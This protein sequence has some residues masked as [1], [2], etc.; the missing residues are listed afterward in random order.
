MLDEWPMSGAETA[1]PPQSEAEAL[2]AELSARDD[3]RRAPDVIDAALELLQKWLQ[4]RRAGAAAI[5]VTRA[6]DGRRELLRVAGAGFGSRCPPATRCRRRCRCCARAASRCSSRTADSSPATLGAQRRL[7]TDCRG[8]TCALVARRR[9]GI[10][11]RRDRGAERAPARPRARKPPG[12]ICS[13]RLA[14]ARRGGGRYAARLDVI[15]AGAREL[16]REQRLAARSVAAAGP[17]GDATA[18]RRAT[19]TARRLWMRPRRRRRRAAALSDK[20]WFRSAAAWCSASLARRVRGGGAAV[21]GWRAPRA[22]DGAAGGSGDA[23]GR[24]RLPAAPRRGIRGD[25]AASAAPT[26]SLPEW[27]ILVRLRR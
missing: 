2:C 22:V 21:G 5:G 24:L 11:L 16:W 18:T 20:S 13:G 8:V 7:G 4:R 9:R 27:R 17:A 26:S 10:A 25:A 12:R 23:D 6:D 1:A 19:A 14:R 3:L 15:V